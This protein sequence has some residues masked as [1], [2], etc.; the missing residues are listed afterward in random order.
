MQPLKL[1]L[2]TLALMEPSSEAAAK[3]LPSA[4]KMS[5]ES[6]KERQLVKSRK[7]KNEGSD[8]YEWNQF[9]E[10]LMKKGYQNVDKKFDLKGKGKMKWVKQKL[11]WMQMVTMICG[12]KIKLPD[13]AEERK[14]N[15]CS[16]RRRRGEDILQVNEGEGDWKKVTELEVGAMSKKKVQENNRRGKGACAKLCSI[17]TY[18]RNCF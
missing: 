1:S 3:T 6:A 18:I 9:T 12:A 17:S 14:S 11:G 7:V 13:W 2:C 16:Y 4:K 5:T 10:Q 15:L 8:I